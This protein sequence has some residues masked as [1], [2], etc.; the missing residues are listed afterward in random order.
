[1][2]RWPV[3]VF[4]FVFLV[5]MGNYAKRPLPPADSAPPGVVDFGEPPTEEEARQYGLRLEAA[6]NA[7]DA[8]AF[9]ALLPLADVVRRAV[10]DLTDKPLP[11]D[12][13]AKVRA[14]ITDDLLGG[15]GRGGSFKLLRVRRVG[16]RFQPLFRLVTPEGGVNYFDV[17]LVRATDGTA[18]LDDVTP[19][20]QGESFGRTCRR[21]VLTHAAGER[22]RDQFQDGP[23]RL[24]V[25]HADEVVAFAAHVRK[26]EGK[27]AM[28]LYRRW[29]AELQRDRHLQLNAVFAAAELDDDEAYVRQIEDFRRDH[30]GDPSADLVALDAYVIKGQFDP[31][32]KAIDAL[33]A[34]VGGDPYLDATRGMVLAAAGRLKEAKAA[35]AQAARAEPTLPVVGK[36]RAVIA[37]AERGGRR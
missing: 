12:V 34:A 30:P 7:R 14:P 8:A 27:A 11:P 13:A 31:A 28:D 24:L 17:A 21:L 23:E 18:A 26:R 16:D 1:M 36:A 33:R 19:M 15:V 4:L 37:E 35:V 20:T 22:L 5:A 9:D 25:D 32:V 2:G 3:F 10:R 29:P 6:V